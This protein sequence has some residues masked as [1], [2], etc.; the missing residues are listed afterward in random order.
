M[1]VSYDETVDVLY[2]TFQPIPPSVTYL[3]NKNGD[4][5]RFDSV[6]GAVVGVTIPC[7]LERA[8]IED[9]VIEEIG[10]VPF[11]AALRQLV[12]ERTRHAKNQQ[13]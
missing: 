8:E 4:I 6:S 13:A 7:F 3:E 11:N 1:K 12:M 5:I 2:V 9:V 10:S